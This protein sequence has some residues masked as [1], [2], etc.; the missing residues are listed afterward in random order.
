SVIKGVLGIVQ[1]QESATCINYTILALI[2]KV[3]NPSLLS[4]FRPISLCNVFCKI[5]SKIITNHL[6]FILPDII[7]EEKSAFIPGR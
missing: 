4:Q 1:G 5:S 7:S 3:T 2:P 6:K